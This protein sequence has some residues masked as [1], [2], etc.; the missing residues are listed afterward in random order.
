MEVGI[1]YMSGA[2]RSS[3]A[4]SIPVVCILA[5]GG[6]RPPTCQR[7]SGNCRVGRCLGRSGFSFGQTRVV[8]ACCAEH[9]RE[10]LTPV[11]E[12]ARLPAFERPESRYGVGEV[13]VVGGRLPSWWSYTL[14]R[15]CSQN[16]VA[17]YSQS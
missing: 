7:K 11:S 10:R 2:W 17:R 14:V 3:F 13:A 12:T 5:Q 4:L 9:H 1:D 8:C 16:G 15:S 6:L